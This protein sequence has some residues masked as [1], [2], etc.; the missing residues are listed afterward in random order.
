MLLVLRPAGGLFPHTW[1]LPG[2]DL[3]RGEDA[4]TAA[5]RILADTL[6]LELGRGMFLAALDQ[7]TNLRDERGPDTVL[8]VEVAG[9]N[10]KVRFGWTEARFVD[11]SSMSGLRMFRE[12]RE[13]IVDLSARAAEAVPA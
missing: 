6:G 12:G 5:R 7:P 2:G 11:T 9:G 8:L 1:T 10:P 13:L 3:L 4:L